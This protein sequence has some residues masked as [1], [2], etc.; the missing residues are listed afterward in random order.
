MAFANIVFQRSADREENAE[1]RIEINA[2]TKDYSS[3]GAVYAG[4]AI[5]FIYSDGSEYIGKDFVTSG[6]T[7]DTAVMEYI[8]DCPVD[9]TAVQNGVGPAY[10]GGTFG[11]NCFNIGDEDARSVNLAIVAPEYDYTVTAVQSATSSSVTTRTEQTAFT[12]SRRRI[13]VAFAD[14]I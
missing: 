14:R 11:Y 12:M 13:Y 6:E 1:T 9:V 5:G 7:K 3:S 4:G 2:S 10:A 8:F